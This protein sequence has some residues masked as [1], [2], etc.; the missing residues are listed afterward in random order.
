MLKKQLNLS[1]RLCS[2][3]LARLLS[4]LGFESGWFDEI[5]FLNLTQKW[6]EK[7]DENIFKNLPS[8]NVLYLTGVLWVVEN[9]WAANQS[10]PKNQHI[11]ELSF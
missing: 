4:Y 10:L 2:G 5:S 7:E 3:Q 6:H 11:V 1:D 8:K 9:F